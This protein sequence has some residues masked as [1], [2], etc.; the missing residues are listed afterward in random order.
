MNTKKMVLKTNREMALRASKSTT[1]QN[2]CPEQ[3][4]LKHILQVCFEFYFLTNA[5][6]TQT[7]IYTISLLVRRDRTM[8]FP[9]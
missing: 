4:I 6:D 8:S 7:A 5:K 3:E 1:I 2:V 9:K